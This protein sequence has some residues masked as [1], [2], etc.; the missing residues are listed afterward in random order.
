MQFV[1]NLGMVQH[2]IGPSLPTVDIKKIEVVI[3]YHCEVL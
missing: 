3:V 2:V 1:A